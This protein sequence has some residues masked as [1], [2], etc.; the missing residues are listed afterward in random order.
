MCVECHIPTYGVA[1]CPWLFL[2]G[3]GCILC[4][5]C[6][7]QEKQME[8]LRPN[9]P[10][11]NLQF[12]EEKIFEHATSTPGGGYVRMYSSSLF[13]SMMYIMY[14]HM[15][16]RHES[17]RWILSDNYYYFLQYSITFRRYNSEDWTNGAELLQ[18]SLF[19]HLRNLALG[20]RKNS[21]HATRWLSPA[22]AASM[23]LP[24]VLTFLTADWQE[25]R[26]AP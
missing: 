5:K 23:L 1:W 6:L 13:A 4:V 7:F 14:I 15:Y 11:F 16:A 9:T 8:S 12:W 26:Q 24:C 19:L 3:V 22:T 17:H 18:G 10:Q 2:S 25:T 21:C 20:T